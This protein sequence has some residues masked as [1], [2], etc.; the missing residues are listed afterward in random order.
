[1]SNGSESKCNMTGCKQ[2]SNKV[3]GPD[4]AS[5]SLALNETRFRLTEKGFY[6]DFHFVD[7][8][9]EAVRKFNFGIHFDDIW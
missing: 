2:Y 1:M 6:C 3:H 5:Y 8:I 4:I 9:L 7:N